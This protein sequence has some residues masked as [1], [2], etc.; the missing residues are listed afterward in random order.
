MKISIDKN[1][2]T[3]LSIQLKNSIKDLI[4]KGY[5]KNGD[6][7][8]TTRMLSESL[9]I[10]RNTVISA[11][12][13]LEAEGFV[14]SHVGRGTFIIIPDQ[15]PAESSIAFYNVFDWTQ[16]LSEKLTQ[17]ISH[18]LLTLYQSESS[19]IRISF[20]WS[21]KGFADYPVEKFHR[22]MNSVFR[23]KTSSVFDYTRSTGDRG[24]Q[25]IIANH[26]HMK[27]INI[28]PENILIVNGAQQA[29]DLVGKVLLEP[30]DVV[31]VENPT[32]TGALCSFQFLRAKI[33]GIPVDDWGMKVHML[34]E[35]L[36]R[37]R[38]KFIFTI[39]T[40]HNPT[41]STMRSDRRERIVSLAEKYEIPIVEDDYGSD[42]QFSGPEIPLLKSLDTSGQVIYIGTFS[43][44]LMP[45]L[46]VGW[47]AASEEV[48]QPLAELK[49]YSDLC[50]SP[51]IQASITEFHARGYMA[52]HIRYLKR[53]YQKRLHTILEAIREHFPPE[54]SFIVPN[55]GI[56]LWVTL[57]GHIHLR[58]VWDNALKRGVAFSL[59][60]LF[61]L[62]ENG[63]NQMRLRYASVTEEQIQEGIRII[64]EEIQKAGEP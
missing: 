37:Y 2:S 25:S 21:Q 12:K 50:T 59:G 52:T 42:L 33:I 32:Y 34:E 4:S 26:L 57:P 38:P 1:A 27:G 41:G 13:A 60:N 6:T 29:I 54:T 5:F 47:I 11:Y 7:L 36:V 61:Y 20:V 19:K 46:R 39:P 15:Q 56:Y 49:R 44:I 51:L 23:E 9:G 58:T 53:V 16:H 30:G 17:R 63:S 35:V 8:P 22:S 48:I 43:K 40:F 10:H 64:G 14:Y 62:N 45:G 3:P 55:G 28:S 31:V 18:K 24:L